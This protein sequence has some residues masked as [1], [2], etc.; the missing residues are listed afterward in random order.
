MFAP[1][2]VPF[3]TP[4]TASP[5]AA[6]SIAPTT[7][8]VDPVFCVYTDAVTAYAVDVVQ[9]ETQHV[10]AIP[11]TQRHT[12][13]QL[14]ATVDIDFKLETSDGV[15]LLDYSTGTNWA[16]SLTEYTYSGM[17]FDF[18]VDGCDEDIT[19]GPYYDGSSY[20]VVGSS[21]YYNEY[22]YV[23][24][25]TEDLVVSAVGYGSGTGTLS[26]LFDCPGTC[27]TC[28][29]ATFAPSP[30]PSATPTTAAPTTGGDDDADDS[31]PPAALSLFLTTPALSTTPSVAPTTCTVDPVFCVY[32]D[33][34]TAYAIDVAQGETQEVSAIPAS[35]RRTWIQL[36]A[37][38]DIDLKLETS[39]GVVLLD[40]STGTN[41]ANSLTEYTYAGMTF[42]FCVD[43]C[44]ED[45]TVGPYY[46]GSSYNV[47]GDASYYNEYVYVDRATEDLVVS[48]VGYGSGTGTLSVLYDCPGTGAD[49]GGADGDADD[50]PASTMAPSA[51]P[52]PAPSSSSPSGAP[53]AFASKA[54]LSTAVDAWFADADA[55]AL[56]YGHISTWDTSAVTDMSELF[57]IYPDYTTF[58]DDIG[59]W[60]TSSVT[61]MSHMFVRANNFN[62]DIGGWDTA[63]VTDMNNMFR[64]AHAFNCDIGGW[65][66]SSVKGINAMFRNAVTFNQDIG[67]WDTSAVIAMGNMFQQANAFNQDIGA[68]DVSSVTSTYQM[69]WERGDLRPGS[70][71]V[72]LV[73]S[74]EHRADV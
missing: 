22:V 27:C 55:A 39:G 18:C 11:A 17:T 50:S 45:I 38:A 67:A 32:T 36:D 7:C 62:Q 3:A 48:A 28:A 72:G 35:Q 26:V 5:S 15:V 20:D 68:W 19:V 1:S 23:D 61:D 4:T 69:F 37:T 12:W 34:V 64:D 31:P 16:N 10:S 57:S 59:G 53:F 29:A 2:P 9:G 41:W 52:S 60:D 71:R 73:E 14:N 13:I 74:D 21:S 70:R 25:A 43:G 51:E 49:D 58:N 8:T 24:R 54:D 63:S 40:Y 6:P 66:T 65:D 42:D 56:A 44:D 46:D 30:A 47:T 33:A